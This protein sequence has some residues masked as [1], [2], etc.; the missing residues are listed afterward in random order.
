MAEEHNQ[1]TD[2]LMELFQQKDDTTNQ[3]GDNAP[4]EAPQTKRGS[5]LIVN[6]IRTELLQQEITEEEY[7]QKADPEAEYIAK[8]NKYTDPLDNTS[9][10]TTTYYCTPPATPEELLLLIADKTRKAQEETARNTRIIK[11][12]IVALL[13]LSIIAGIIIAIAEITGG[14]NTPTYYPYY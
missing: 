4:N 9:H 2:P 11:N 10:T 5:S 6:K 8:E 13:I 1:K 14:H 3:Q 7:N 12:I